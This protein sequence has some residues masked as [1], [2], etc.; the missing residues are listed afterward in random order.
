[1]ALN[2]RELAH[3]L[4]GSAKYTTLRRYQRRAGPQQRR[5]ITKEL[6]R[7]EKSG[8][9]TPVAMTPSK[10]SFLPPQLGGP[11][12]GM[13]F[14]PGAGGWQPGGGGGSTPGHLCDQLPEPI[15]TYCRQGADWVGGQLP[16]G[17]GGGGGGGFT[18]AQ[19]CPDGCYRVP[20]TNQ[21]VCPGDLFPG[22][23]PGF[24]GA[25]GVATQGAFGLPALTPAAQQRTTLRCPAGMVLGK[26]NLCYP[27]AVLGRRSKFRKW[28]PDPRPAL[29]AND[30]KT[31]RRAER[32]R[33]KI[34]GLAGDAGFSTK[35]R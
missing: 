21:C 31:L 19:D 7:F 13:P 16:G 10:L 3:A 29:S 5:K 34:K 4:S 26:D 9:A 32:I 30:A 23:D 35:K 1:M 6:K 33:K 14:N 17:N 28:R 11:G 18:P 12:G 27:K 15:A 22:G 25:G 20:A 8:G 2:R 24:V